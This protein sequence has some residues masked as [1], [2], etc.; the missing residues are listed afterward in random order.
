M[1]EIAGPLL[2]NWL[3]DSYGWYNTCDYIA[4]AM[5]IYAVIYFVFCWVLGK[6]NINRVRSALSIFEEPDKALHLDD[7]ELETEEQAKELDALMAVEMKQEIL[8]YIKLFDRSRSKTD[9]NVHRKRPEEEDL[10]K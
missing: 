9:W 3:Y 1:G 2:G 10:T 5:V 8:E 6:K 4:L 7:F